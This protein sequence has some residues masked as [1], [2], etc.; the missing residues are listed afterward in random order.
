M[1][2]IGARDPRNQAHNFLGYKYQ[3]ADRSATMTFERTQQ[4]STKTK[5]MGPEDVYTEHE[6][7]ATARQVAKEE[8][9]KGRP[10]FARQA[11]EYESKVHP[12]FLDKTGYWVQ[13]ALPTLLAPSQTQNMT[14]TGRLDSTK[15]LAQAARPIAAVHSYNDVSPVLTSEYTHDPDKSEVAWGNT[16]NRRGRTGMPDSTPAP[17][18]PMQTIL[19]TQLIPEHMKRTTKDVGDAKVRSESVGSFWNRQTDGTSLNV[20]DVGRIGDELSSHAVAG[21]ANSR[22]VGGKWRYLER[23]KDGGSLYTEFYGPVGGGET[24]SDYY[25]RSYKYLPQ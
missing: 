19:T 16:I 4:L 6:L 17:L 2:G 18:T 14:T 3:H 22:L 20:K 23:P 12:P 7:A 24:N 9:E 25:G 13:E 8:K 1:A 21:S 15:G 5:V 11:T 10:Q